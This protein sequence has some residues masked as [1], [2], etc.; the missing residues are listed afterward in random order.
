M[1]FTVTVIGPAVQALHKQASVSLFSADEEKSNSQQNENE[2]F[3][4]ESDKHFITGTLQFQQ[5]EYPD[6]NFVVLPKRISSPFLE[7]A[8]PPPDLS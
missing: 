1:I 5:K 3:K 2:G 8:A 4:K 6:F 7:Y